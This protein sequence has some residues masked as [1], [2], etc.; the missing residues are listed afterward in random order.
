MNGDRS[1]AVRY[2]RDP[3]MTWR[4]TGR[5]VLVAPVDRLVEVMVLEGGGAVIWRLLD[6]PDTATGI[7]GRLAEL[8]GAPDVA[9]VEACLALLTTQGVLRADEPEAPS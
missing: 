4:D 7:A 9:E 2:G 5:H 3:A 8:E 6:E 1:S